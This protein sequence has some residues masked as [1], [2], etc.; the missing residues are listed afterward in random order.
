MLAGHL[1]GKRG[2]AWQRAGC[3]Q[4]CDDTPE[5]VGKRK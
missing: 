2:E 5:A 1:R 4:V 3:Q